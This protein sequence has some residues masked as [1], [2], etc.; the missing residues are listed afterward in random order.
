MSPESPLLRRDLSR[1]GQ[2][3]HIAVWNHLEVDRQAGA[4]EGGIAA[5]GRARA[6]GVPIDHA[7]GVST[8]GRE[9]HQAV[10]ADARPPVAHRDDAFR[11]QVGGLDGT[12]RRA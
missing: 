7:D 6:V 8:L 12:V 3:P 5:H 1:V 2:Q 10:A 4:A 9:Q 11:R